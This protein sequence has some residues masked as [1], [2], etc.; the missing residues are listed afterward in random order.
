MANTQLGDTEQMSYTVTELDADSNP[1]TP[2]PG[3]TCVVSSSAS[4]SASVVP[5]ATPVAGSIASGQIVGGKALATGVSISALVTHADGTTLGPVTALV[6]VVGGV[7]SSI[8]IGF[9]APVAQAPATPPA[10]AAAAR[11]LAIKS[12]K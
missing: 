3:D 6:D 10:A 9:G 12:V 5:D 1:A 8:S 2:L 4:A 7:A 11:A